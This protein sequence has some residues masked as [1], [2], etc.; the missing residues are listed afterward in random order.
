M[1]RSGEW[2]SHKQEAFQAKGNPAAQYTDVPSVGPRERLVRQNLWNPYIQPMQPSSD[3]V[4]VCWSLSE[5][6]P[7]RPARPTS[8]IS[9][10]LGQYVPNSQEGQPPWT[11]PGN[12][13]V[14]VFTHNTEWSV[15]AR[16]KHHVSHFLTAL[17]P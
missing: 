5:L 15:D 4:L 3:P 16:I 9:M 13:G 11:E 14:A 17:L 6:A 2:I 12:A 7:H 10:D 8:V 1:Q